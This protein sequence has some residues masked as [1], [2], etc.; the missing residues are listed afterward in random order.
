MQT[1]FGTTIDGSHKLLVVLFDHRTSGGLFPYQGS[2]LT[3][4][5]PPTSAPVVN[6]S[7]TSWRSTVEAQLTDQPIQPSLTEPDP[8]HCP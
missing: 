4:F 1:G 8:I 5:K 3:A 2:M 7:T 6:I